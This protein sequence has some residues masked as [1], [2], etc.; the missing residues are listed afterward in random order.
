MQRTPRAAAFFGG[1]AGR[2][3]MVALAGAIVSCAALV[4]IDDRLPDDA[5]TAS[6]A[7]PDVVAP[8][9]DAEA[10]D[11]GSGLPTYGVGDGHTGARTIASNV[12][13]NSY[14]RLIDAAS[15]TTKLGIGAVRGDLFTVGDLVIVWQTATPTPLASNG[16]TIDLSSSDVG[17]WEVARVTAIETINEGGPDL[18]FNLTLDHAVGAAHPFASLGAQVIRVPEYTDL[19]IQLNQAIYAANW[20]GTN[21]G[22]AAVYVSGT[23]KNDGAISA[24]NSGFRGAV[25]VFTNGSL[26]NCSSPDGVPD[27]G[28]APKGEGIVVGAYSD[29]G[30]LGN[31]TTGG[32]GGDC[33]NAGGGGGGNGGQGGK[34]GLSGDNDRD[35]GGRGGAALSYPSVLERVTFGGGGGAGEEDNGTLR[36]GGNGGG[37]VIVRAKDIVLP[38]GRY[39]ARGGSPNRADQSGGAGGGGGGTIILQ[40]G[41]TMGCQQATVRGGTGATL[42]TTNANNGP[43]GGGAGG[44]ALVQGAVTACSIETRAGSAGRDNTQ[45][46]PTKGALPEAG[47]ELDLPF[48]VAPTVMPTAYCTTCP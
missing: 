9:P 30:G 19:T 2:I 41:A 33:N 8:T 23:L 27:A 32:G 11:A 44:R 40:S 18:N 21:G 20:D 15:N 46:G 43:G 3:A 39:L 24:D 17:Q 34:G 6:D 35:V 22:V 42:E 37:V 47:A 36:N 28:Y 29:G 45:T 5:A 26:N 4:G 12:V 13:V 14:A 7:A 10:P 31:A 48:A 1:R 16:P 25:A 38:G